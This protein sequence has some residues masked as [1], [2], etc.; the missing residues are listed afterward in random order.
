MNFYVVV[1]VVFVDVLD[2]FFVPPVVVV[3]GDIP[4]LVGVGVVAVDSSQQCRNRDNNT[5]NNTGNSRKVFHKD[6]RTFYRKNIYYFCLN[7]CQLH[8]L[9]E[10]KS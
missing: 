3:V 8:S 10:T 9:I 6:I 2:D 1:A 5:N 4:V 7:F